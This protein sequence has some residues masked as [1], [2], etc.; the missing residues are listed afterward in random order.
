EV[1]G[2][3]AIDMLQALNVGQDGSLSTIH[4]NSAFDAISRLETMIMLHTDIPLAALRRQIASGIDLIVHLGRLRDK[5]RR[6]IEIRE[7]CGIENDGIKTAV[8]FQ[9]A[10]EKEEDGKIAGSIIKQEALCHVQKLKTAGINYE[11]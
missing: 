7:L 8:L 3:E 5:S 11:A 1:R 10:E 2:A 4:A 6:L 9:F